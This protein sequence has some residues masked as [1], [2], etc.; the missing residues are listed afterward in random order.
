MY[1][2]LTHLVTLGQKLSVTK[3]SFMHN[4]KLC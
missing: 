2:L 1:A 4:S 3:F